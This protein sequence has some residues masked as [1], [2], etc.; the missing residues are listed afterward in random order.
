MTVKELMD[1]GW[2]KV[3]N[4]GDDTERDIEKVFKPF[5]RSLDGADEKELEMF[6]AAVDALSNKWHEFSEDVIANE[7][8]EKMTE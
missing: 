3:I 2:F 1:K 4:E 7:M 5:F 8:I 6:R